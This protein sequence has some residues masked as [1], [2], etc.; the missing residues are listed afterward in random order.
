MTE[1]LKVLANTV[2]VGTTNNTIS[3][4]KYVSLLNTDTVLGL[5]TTFDTVANVQIGN[6][7]LAPNE[8]FNLRKRTTDAITANSATKM[9]ATPISSN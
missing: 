4:A 1:Y 3:G 2:A 7:Q 5:V 8:R 9:L 6:I